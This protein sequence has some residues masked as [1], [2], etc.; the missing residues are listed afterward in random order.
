MDCGLDIVYCYSFLLVAGATSLSD[1]WDFYLGGT[2]F[3][4]GQDF[5]CPA[6]HFSLQANTGY[7]RVTFFKI[8]VHSSLCKHS[9]LDATYFGILTE[10]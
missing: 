1:A 10:L 9:T 8:H 5:V 4:F 7:A 3:E 2:G 6:P